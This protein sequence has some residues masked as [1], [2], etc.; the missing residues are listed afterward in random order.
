MNGYLESVVMR[1]MSSLEKAKETTYDEDSYKDAMRKILYFHVREVLKEQRK[2]LLRVIEWKAPQEKMSK[3]IIKNF[4][5]KD[6]S[7]KR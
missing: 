6:L 1:I 2:Q 5:V 3:L 7:K 4:Y